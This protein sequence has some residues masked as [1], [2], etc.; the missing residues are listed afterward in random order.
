MKKNR[1]VIYVNE[2][3]D[4]FYFN[5]FSLIEMQQEDL[6]LELRKDDLLL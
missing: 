5:P 4:Y 2:L 3:P 1:N 6:K